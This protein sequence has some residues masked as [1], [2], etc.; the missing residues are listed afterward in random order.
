MNFVA[1]YMLLTGLL[2]FGQW[3]FFLATGQ[4]PDLQTAPWEIGYHLIAEF[5]TAGAL[6]VAGMGIFKSTPWSKNLARIALGMLLYTV[7]NSAGYFAQRSV[8]P[9]VVMFAVL[10]V[11]DVTSLTLLGVKRDRT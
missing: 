7:I 10:T 6:L 3:A 4:V 9:L 11:L 8:W 5:L 1:Y 2:M